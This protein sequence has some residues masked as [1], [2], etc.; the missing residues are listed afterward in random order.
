[1]SGTQPNQ[2]PKDDYTHLVER[3]SHND[4]EAFGQLYDHFYDRVLS[5]AF[6]F[7][8]SRELAEEIVH[9]VFL[10]VWQN[11]Q[12][13]NASL[14]LSGFIFKITHNL[15]LNALRTRVEEPRYFEVVRESDVV[16]CKTENDVIA[17]EMQECID[18]AIDALPTKR[19]RIFVLSKMQGYTNKEIANELNISTNTVAGQLRKATKTLKDTL[20]FAASI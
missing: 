4:M 12:K 2:L 20:K 14:S 13:L 7:L 1:M 5:F 10:K 8:K 17:K 3:I 16:A 6:K 11:R 9:D 15:M 19:R 18:N